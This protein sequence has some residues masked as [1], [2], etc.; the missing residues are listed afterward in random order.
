MS[1]ALKNNPYISIIYAVVFL[2]GLAI[3]VSIHNASAV[4]EQDVIFVREDGGISTPPP[5]HDHATSTENTAS[6]TDS[7]IESAPE[8]DTSL[9]KYIRVTDGCG[10]HYE[11]DCLNVRSGPGTDHPVVAYLR[12]GIVLKVAEIIEGEEH[13]WYKIVFDEWLRYPERVQDEWYIAAEYVELFYDEGT[14][15]IWGRDIA[16]SSKELIIDRSDQMLYAYDGDELVMEES[17]STGLDITPT[18]RGT[19]TVFRKTPSR[20][21]QGP[22]PGITEQY[23]DLPGVPWNLY[24]THGGAVIHGAYWHNDFGK[25][26]SNGCVNVLPDQARRIYEW[27]EIGMDVIVRD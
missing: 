15:E 3:G 27:A 26:H 19:F 6:S 18:P 8:V 11:G 13:T 2:S 23:Y 4:T 25:Q 22:I 16:T 21:M 17:V 20:Y 10:P 24:F 12:N 7:E 9:P 14:I 5:T 1:E